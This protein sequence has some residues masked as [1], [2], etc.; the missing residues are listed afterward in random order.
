MNDE[1]RISSPGLNIS[2]DSDKFVKGIFMTQN[3]GIDFLPIKIDKVFPELIWLHANECNIKEI[4]KENFENLSKLKYVWL[5]FNKITQI[6][7]DTFSNL[8]SL[9]QIYLGESFH[10]IFI[11]KF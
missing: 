10:S 6:E 7:S 5:G 8:K 3:K 1:T 4:H 11:D 9:S 2:E